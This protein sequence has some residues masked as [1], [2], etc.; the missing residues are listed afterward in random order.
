[1]SSRLFILAR[2][3]KATAVIEFALVL[4][5]MLLL[6]MG[7][8][9]VSYQGYMQSVLSG[10]MQKAGRDSTIQGNSTSSV[11]TAVLAQVRSVNRNAAFVAGY[12]LRQS[13]NAFGAIKPEPFTDSNGNG[14]RDPGE[15]FSDVNGNGVWDAN[16]GIAG[17]GGASDAVVYT[18][19]ITY[20][21]L[22]PV[23]MLLG[24]NRLTTMSATT[25]LKNQPYAAQTSSI[26]A[27]VC[28]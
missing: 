26:P 18:V 14:V 24:W 23:A 6:I 4:P 22:F 10:A 20:P 7:M 1:M 16:P 19:S 15:C 2:D 5:A 13:F 11:D 8:S 12:P 28:T 21:R 3:S 17:Q 9:E 25:I 27:T